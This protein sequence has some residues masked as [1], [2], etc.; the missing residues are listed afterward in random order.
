MA[1][2]VIIYTTNYCG[3]CRRAKELFRGKGIAF[4]EINLEEDPALM[5]AIRDKY[6]W[7]TVPMIVVNDQFLGGFD[8]INALDKKGELDPLLK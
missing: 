3:Y 8:E 1:A 6:N 5:K 2:K 4:E 7:R